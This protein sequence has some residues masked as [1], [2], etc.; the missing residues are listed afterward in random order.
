VRNKLLV[1]ILA[2]VA[3]VLAACSLPDV[4]ASVKSASQR[5]A[6]AAV[7]PEPAA[8]TEL[9]KVEEH[10]YCL[11]YPIGYSIERPNPEETVLV[12]GSLLDV[13]NPRVYIKVNNADGR[14]VEQAADAVV[15]DFPGFEIVR[16]SAAIGGQ[17]AIVLD[18][19]P[20]QDMSRQIV[21]VRNDRL[22]RLTFVPASED[23]GEVYTR[24]E[25]FYQI[26]L[27]SMSF[28]G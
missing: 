18:G 25:Q 16:S 3:T 1:V 13:S 24:M 2:L 11:L 19:V 28:L 17:A 27:D 7:C 12:V 5:D 10:G 15:A 21:V 20:G 23:A 9:L 22:Y 4:A 8:G 14:T 6:P 26:V